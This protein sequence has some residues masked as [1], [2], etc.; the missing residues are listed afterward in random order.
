MSKTCGKCHNYKNGKCY[1]NNTLVC[2]ESIHPCWYFKKKPTNGDKIRAMSNADLAEMLVYPVKPMNVNGNIYYEF[3]S[4]LLFG[5]S[6]PMREQAVLLTERRLNAP[7]DCVKQNGNH[8]TQADLCKVD[9]TESEG[10]NE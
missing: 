2:A 1:F 10:E 7:A 9:N 3:T 4:C 6:Y 5:K 8:H